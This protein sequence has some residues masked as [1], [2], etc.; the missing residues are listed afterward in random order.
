MQEENAEEVWKDVVNYE[1]LYKVSNLGRVKRLSRSRLRLGGKPLNLRE[2]VLKPNHIGNSYY[3]LK[4]TK[5]EV[6]TSILL[7][8][9]VCEAFHGSAPVGKNFVNHKDTNKENNR[10]DN[11]EWCSF[12]EN[13][14]H[15][16]LHGL[17]PRGSGN[18]YHKIKEDQVLEICDL[19]DNS[20]VSNNEIADIYG[21]NHRTISSIK[22]GDSWNWLTN[23]KS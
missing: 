6:E 12:K 1:G 17:R 3:Q 10:E 15:A 14:E 7:H 22:Y 20:S 19:L 5:D 16:A 18:H 4:L 9:I 2:K 13:M 8:R 11:L 23:R 21:V